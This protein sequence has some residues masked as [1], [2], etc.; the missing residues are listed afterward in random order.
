MAK[1][2]RALPTRS[3]FYGK[4]LDLRMSEYKAG[5]WAD[6]TPTYDGPQTESNKHDADAHANELLE[7]F[8]RLVSEAKR[9]G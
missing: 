8:D 4:L 2:S 3:E 5:L 7:M 1:E 9:N 6:E